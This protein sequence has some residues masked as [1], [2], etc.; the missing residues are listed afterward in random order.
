MQKFT[1]TIPLSLYI[2]LPWCVRKC[3]YCDFNSHAAPQSLPEELY[4]NALIKDFEEQLPK[5]W[6]RRLVS[7]FFGGGTPSLFSSAAISRILTAIHT[8]LPFGP[9]IE[10]TLEANPGTLD[11]TRFT[12]FRKAG[13]NR[14]SLG[15][16]SLQDEKLTA[17]GRIHNREFALRAIDVAMRAGFANFNLDFMHGLPNQTVL[18]ALSDLSTAIDYHPPHVSWYQL[19]IEPNTFF[20]H[21]PPSLPAEEILGDI[22]EQGK[23]L[24]TQHGYQQYE[25]SAYS[26][27]EYE[28][29]H[30][31]NYWEFGD[32][33]GI[34]AGAHSKI[35][36]VE[37][38]IIS[39]H[40]QV[41]NPR[42]YL[43][44]SQKFI[45][46]EKVLTE[47]E[48]IFEFMLNALRLVK[49]VSLELFTERTGLPV[50]LL[51]P[52]LSNAINK[53]LLVA[54]PILLCPTPLGARFLDDLV[55][56]FLNH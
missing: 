12:D 44:P 16:Q 31:K 32:Y 30:N 42:D 46:E 9:D 38:Q 36:N 33:L 48:S 24:L 43:D 6:G 40:W 53:D 21:Q 51:E 27:P 28:C 17:L 41:K 29:V 8:R 15:I 14:L 26:Q 1:T 5:I 49:G 45:A 34:G 39:R 2:H 25:V 37:K 50:T 20:H 7:I 13:V 10:I 4:V 11:E 47:K 55:G 3:P 23:L 52:L 19:T 54:D 18:D 22:Q 56:M 35:T